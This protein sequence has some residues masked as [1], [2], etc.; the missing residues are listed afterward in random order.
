MVSGLRC[1]FGTISF[2]VKVKDTDDSEEIQLCVANT[3]VS[4]LPAMPT[5]TIVTGDVDSA[6]GVSAVAVGAAIVLASSAVRLLRTAL[7]HSCS[8]QDG[9][10]VDDDGRE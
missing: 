6:M 3:S 5:Q 2:R 10:D 4:I 9:F 1:L 7:A 8:I